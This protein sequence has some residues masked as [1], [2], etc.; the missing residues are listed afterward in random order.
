MSPHSPETFTGPRS[1]PADCRLRVAIVAPS[2][3]I[4]G[5]QSVQAQRLLDNWAGDPDVNAFLV[6]VNPR[7]PAPLSLARMVRGVRTIVT[8]AIYWPS[9]FR[10]LPAADVVHVFSAS[11]LSFVLAPLPAIIAARLLRRRVLLNYHSGEAPDHLR[12]SALARAVIRRCDLVAVQSA[13]LA[14]VFDE[15]G[16][17][18]RVVPNTLDLDRFPFRRREPLGLNLLSTRSLEPM[19]NVACTLRA[20]QLV[21]ARHPRATLTVAGSGSQFPFLVDLAGRLRLQHVRFI[22]SVPPSEVW[23]LY[24]E[25]DIYLQTPDIDN[26][27]LSVLEAYSS[28]TPVVATAVGGVPAILED[29][30][31]GL[32]APPNDHEAVAAMVLRLIDDTGLAGRLATAARASCER[33]RWS[34][35]RGEWLSLYRELA[36]D[37]VPAAAEVRHA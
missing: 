12:R 8:Q 35:V 34:R 17:G 32:L 1:R 24:S 27:P 13:F 26:M 25:A 14:G 15:H 7:P 21:Q 5:G 2:L 10:R 18:C 30:L 6:A 29:G 36:G 22:G 16:I 20:F 37:R 4:L 11:Y 3:D 33:Y 28:G 31:H 23:R 9:L 19:Y